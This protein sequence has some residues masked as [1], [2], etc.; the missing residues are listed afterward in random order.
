MY[1]QTSENIFL[2]SFRELLK[3]GYFVVALTIM[4][5]NHPVSAQGFDIPPRWPICLSASV[6]L[7][8]AW[9]AQVQ[10]MVSKLVWAKYIFK[11]L[12]NNFAA[13]I[14]PTAKKHLHLIH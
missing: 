9:A 6:R 11:P 4:N 7:A 5:D 13:V 1:F 12:V 14:L 2:P 3:N 8:Q 10:Q